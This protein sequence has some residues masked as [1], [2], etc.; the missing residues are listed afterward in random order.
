MYISIL[1]SVSKSLDSTF[2]SV[3]ACI[4]E[5]IFLQGDLRYEFTGVYPAQ[6]FFEINQETGQV[7]LKKNLKEDVARADKYTVSRWH[8]F[9]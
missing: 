7:I 8:S 4:F 9:F 2:G 6:D 1:V 3:Y 5:H